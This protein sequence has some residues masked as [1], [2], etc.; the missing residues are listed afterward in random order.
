M[1]FA[2]HEEK[3]LSNNLY[4]ITYIFLVQVQ[5]EMRLQP[6]HLKPVQPRDAANRNKLNLER[7]SILSLY[8]GTLRVLQN[9]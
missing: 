3:S 4:E 7:S 9:I 6:V 5:F 8:R 1:R 2:T